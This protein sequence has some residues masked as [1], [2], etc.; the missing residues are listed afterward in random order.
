MRKLILLVAAICGIAMSGQSQTVWQII[1]DS[2]NHNTLEAAVLAAGLDGAL[3]DG[4]ASLTV[5]APDDAAFAALG[6]DVIDELLADPSGDLTQILLYHV[7]GQIVFSGNLADGQSWTTLQGQDVGVS[8]VGGTVFIND[9]Q[10]TA[11][12]LDGENGVLH[13]INGV[14][15][16][17]LVCTDFAAGPYIDFNTIFGGA[18]NSVDGVCPVNQITTFEAWASE[19]Y[20]VNNFVEGIEYTFSICD[21]PG[22]GTWDAELTVSTLE[23]VVVASVE[24]CSLTWTS[25]GSGT[26]LIGVQEVGFCGDESSNLETNNGYPTLTCTGVV[27]QNSIWDIVVNS[28][29][30][31]TLETAIGLAGLDGVLSNPGAFTLFAPT[32]AAFAALPDGVLDAL[33]ADP[34][35]ALTDV[36]LYHVVGAVAL[37]GSLSDGQEIITLQGQPVV[38]S[39]V[40]GNVFIN[41]AQVTVAD[42]VADNGVVHV[43]NAVLVPEAAPCTDFASGPYNNFNTLFGGAPVPDANGD[44]PVNQITD[45][46]AWASESYIVES[47]EAGITYTFSICDGPGAGSW[48]AE[49]SV[50]N[51]ANELIAQAQGCEITWICPEDGTYILGIQEVG[52]CGDASPN[53]QVDNGFPTLTCSGPATIWDV[54]RTSSVHNTLESV[55]LLAG[56][57][58]ALDAPGSLTL[59]APTDEAFANV[60]QST[61]D[62]LLA[63]PTGLLTQVLTYHV[64]GAAALSGSLSDGQILPTL[65]GEGLQVTI[66]MGAVMVGNANGNATVTVADIEVSNGVVH[67]ID[68]VLVPATLSTDHM[69]FVNSIKVFPNP[70][71]YQFTLDVDLS[72]A[73]RVTVDLVNLLGQN[74]K[75]IDLGQRSNGLTREYI[76]VN[77]V[78]AGFY[79]MNITVGNSQ[80]VQ[81]VQIAR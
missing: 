9:A 62:A 77:D 37:S 12:N 65:N 48:D 28:A 32:D 1:Q 29:D 25:P 42:L 71:N 40:G 46:E 15:L 64:I 35:G 5:F 34:S 80:V 66:E 57:D 50:L 23:G 26:Y 30:H 21:G 20:T 75:S 76:D 17:V 27:L 59:F 56:L 19:Q 24:G 2:P 49:L 67:V 72:S 43:I 45:F 7:L 69:E 51:E 44:C 41:D 79:L 55:L 74:V 22:A 3:N 38:V 33:I 16:P 53:Q 81:K 36:L 52:F 8:I 6:Q 78:P 63:D 10:V 4:G 60:P 11:A 54:V 39:I 47:F 58:G 14:L 18:P 13:V 31:T 73:N 70:T 68:A 61:L